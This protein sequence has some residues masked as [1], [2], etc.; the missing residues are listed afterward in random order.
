LRIFLNEGCSAEVQGGESFEPQFN[1]FVF[2]GIWIQLLIDPLC[3]ADL[4]DSL[5][6]PRARTISKAVQR[7][8]NGLIWSEIGDWQTFKNR[9]LF[10]L[11]V[12]C[13]RRSRIGIVC[14]VKAR[15]KK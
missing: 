7:V 15:R 11:S 9:I 1:G 3:Q 13:W 4:F 6:I 8:E 10:L 14:G 2:N 5:N 12:L